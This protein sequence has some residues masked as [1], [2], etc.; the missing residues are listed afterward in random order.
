MGRSTAKRQ[1]GP[2]GL[3][4]F[5]RLGGEMQRLQPGPEMR[6]RHRPLRRACWHERRL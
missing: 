5:D 4:Q 6:S 3:P 1:R 2:A